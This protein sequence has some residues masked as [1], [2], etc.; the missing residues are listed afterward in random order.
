MTAATE[1]GPNKATA[2]YLRAHSLMVVTA[3]SCTGGLI[4]SHLAAVPGAGT[5]LESA[6]VVY[7]PKAKHRSLGVKAETIER[8]NLTSEPVALEM[9]R[10]ALARSDADVAVSNTGVTDDSD[11]DVA[12]GTQCFAWAFRSG[13]RGGCTQTFTETRVFQGSRNEI[14][15]AAADHALER[16]AHYHRRVQS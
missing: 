12:S 9:A 11:P 15:E 4:A 10:C 13:S 7:D 16:I 1:A 2:D 6:F 14:R 5:V 3:E 8:N